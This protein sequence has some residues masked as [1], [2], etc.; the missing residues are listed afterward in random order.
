MRTKGLKGVRGWLLFFCIS[1]TFRPLLTLHTLYLALPLFI[2]APQVGLFF[3]TYYAFSIIIVCYGLYSAFLLWTTNSKAITS[4]KKYLI[5]F[6]AYTFLAAIFPLLSRRS[7]FSEPLSTFILGLRFQF[8]GAIVYAVI[9][10][11]YLTKS[12]R[13]ANTYAQCSQPDAAPNGDLSSY[14]KA[15]E[16]KRSR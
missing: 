16:D 3:I 4:T 5:T 8:V 7:S 13:V 6:V 15:T 9:W 2:D 10:Y 12:E 1:M 11:N 14:A